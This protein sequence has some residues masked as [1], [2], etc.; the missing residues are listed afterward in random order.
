M[1]PVVLGIESGLTGI[2]SDIAFAGGASIGGPLGVVTGVGSSV[3][4][5]A[6]LVPRI[7]E[8]LFKEMDLGKP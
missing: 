5:D 8:T 4:M 3:Y 7:N 1:R 2:L 6:E